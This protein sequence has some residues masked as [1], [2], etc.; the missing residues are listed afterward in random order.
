VKDAVLPDKEKQSMAFQPNQ[1]VFTCTDV[2]LRAAPGYLGDAPPAVLALL[3]ERTACRVIGAATQADELTWWPVRATLPDGR[4]VEGWV[5]AQVGDIQLLTDIADANPP[6]PKVVTPVTPVKPVAPTTQHA[7]RSN[8]LGFYLHSTNNDTGLWDAI[9]R[10]QPPVMLIHEDAANDLLLREIRDFRAPD[11][12]IIGRFYMT[13]DAQRALLESSDPEG[14]GRRFAERILTYD[15][16]KF[17]RRTSSGRLFIDAWMSLNECLPGPASASYREDPVR[18]HRLYDAYDRFQIAFRARLMQEGIEAVAFNFAAGNFSAA[19][20]YLDCFSRTL[21]EYTYLGFHE[22]GWPSLIPGGGTHTGAGLYREVL[23]AARRSDGAPHR[24]IITEAG[25]TR[26]YGHPQNPDEGW[27]NREE[28]LDEARYWES[29]AW[30]N[31]LLDQDDVLGACLYQ[32]GHRGDWATFRHLGADNGGRT[33]RLVDRMAALREALAAP[34]ATPAAAPAPHPMI[35]GNATLAGQVTRDGG[36]VAGVVV[37]LVGDLRQL[38]GV[39]GAVIDLP[40]AVT[41]SRAVTGFRGSLR[42]AWDRFV[43]GEVAGL[44]WAEFKRQAPI[45]NQALA[46]NG[47]RFAAAQHYYLP[48]NP[49]STPA[50]LWDRPVSG[51]RGTIYQAWLDHVQGRVLGMSYAAFRRQVVAYNPAIVQAGGRLLADQQYVLP[52]TVGA[53]RYAGGALPCRSGCARCAA[54]HVGNHRRSG[55]HRR[56][57]DCAAT[58]GAAHRDRAGNG[59]RPA[60]WRIRRH[61]R[62]RICD[63]WPRAALCRR[64]RARAAL[65]WQRAHASLHPARAPPGSAR[66][67]ARD[68]GARRARLSAVRSRRHA[69]EHRPPARGA[70]TCGRTWPLHP[71]GVCRFLQHNRFPHPRRRPFLREARPELL[72]QPAQRRLLPRRLS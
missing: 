70:A 1:E 20:H 11:A 29:L 51:Y 62:A 53:E 46:A 40:G 26:A 38:G 48:E 6:T 58:A 2:N 24:I 61:S 42:S 8:R 55:D 22:Y 33:L 52:R 50:F 15:F 65:V 35:T 44:T 13:N 72:D 31:T 28:M 37:R 43:A 32:V 36:P 56:L 21:A 41:W 3:A 57:G 27:L 34:A 18:Y 17:T 67:G 25:L 64:Q 39:R 30:Y 7:A 54:L 68:G 12:F 9:S 71:A 14:E 49:Q 45:A 16:G 63:R 4:T 5:A 47:G 23:H 69:G 60:S 10:V 19:E 59:R 66:P